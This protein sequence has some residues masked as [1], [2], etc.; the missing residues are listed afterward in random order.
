MRGDRSVEAC[1][2]C[3]AA[4]GSIGLVAHRRRSTTQTRHDPAGQAHGPGRGSKSVQGRPV[5][6][7]ERRRV[8]LRL[9]RLI[10]WRGIE[11]VRRLRV[12]GGDHLDARLAVDSGVMDLQHEGEAT[13]RNAG[14]LVE[15]LDDVQLPQRLREVERAGV[16]PR[17]LDAELPPVAGLGQCEVAHVVFEVELLVLHPVRMIEVGGNPHHLLTEGPRQMQPG[18]EVAQDAL[19]RHGS[20]G[21]GG[22]VVDAD[23]RDVRRRVRP[24]AVDERR[25]LTTQLLHVRPLTSR[26]GKV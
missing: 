11:H 18:L 19:E 7:L 4:R 25:I 8:G 14:D 22:G 3:Q 6:E 1:T 10:R 13:L 9:P 5:A 16:Q 17:S 2:G 20:I 15:A 23:R 24:L 12:D 26:P 21:R